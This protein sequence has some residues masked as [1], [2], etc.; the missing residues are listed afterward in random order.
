[1]FSTFY[2]NPDASIRVSD[3]PC[4]LTLSVSYLLF[5]FSTLFVI[6]YYYFEHFSLSSA[7][8]SFWCVQH[9]IFFLL[10]PVFKILGCS[11]SSIYRQLFQECDAVCPLANNFTDQFGTYVLMCNV[12]HSQIFT[13]SRTQ[14]SQV[15][16]PKGLLPSEPWVLGH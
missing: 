12:L 15:V 3:I 8:L 6:H 4:E 14:D 2:C 9:S 11:S 13:Q 1:M 5:I 16:H 7:L 10:F